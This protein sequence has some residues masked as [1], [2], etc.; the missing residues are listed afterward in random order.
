V[1]QGHHIE[2]AFVIPFKAIRGRGV[3]QSFD[4]LF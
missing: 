4:E 1:E 2:Q 3:P